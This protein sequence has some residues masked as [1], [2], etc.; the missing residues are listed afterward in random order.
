[1]V[2]IRERQLAVFYAYRRRI[3]QGQPVIK[4]EEI[5]EALRLQRTDEEQ[6]SKR[7][8]V[9]I[10][11]PLLE[12][13]ALIRVE[14]VGRIYRY[15]FDNT[16]ASAFFTPQTLSEATFFRRIA[17][18]E[19]EHVIKPVA[20]GKYAWDF[21]GMLKTPGFYPAVKDLFQIVDDHL[22][23]KPSFEELQD[24]FEKPMSVDDLHRLL[25]DS[26]SFVDVLSLWGQHL[27]DPRD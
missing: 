16:A 10:R 7:T 22:G 15:D 2:T 24:H 26:Q 19:A 23:I 13:K 20:D 27:I 9:D 14:K 8:L 4:D 12:A 25:N 6:I 1:M 11:K 18:M 5:V 3:S 17:E 21:V